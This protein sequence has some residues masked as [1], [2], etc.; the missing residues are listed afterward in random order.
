MKTGTT[1][2]VTESRYLLAIACLPCERSGGRQG[3]AARDHC[4]I[5]YGGRAQG[6]S[7]HQYSR[8]VAESGT[9]CDQYDLR[10]SDAGGDR[11][12]MFKKVVATAQTG[13]DQT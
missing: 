5:R 11:A 13:A 7:V 3:G 1:I 6:R 9:A 8:V 2:G 10:P 12:Q 4:A